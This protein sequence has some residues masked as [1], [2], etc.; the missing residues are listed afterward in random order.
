MSQKIFTDED[1]KAFAGLLP[2]APGASVPFTPEAFQS[3]EEA[4]RPVFRLR[5]YTNK[6]REYMGEHLKS[7][8]YGKDC[9][10]T[11]MESGAVAGWENLRSLPDGESIPFGKGILADLPDVVFFQIHDRI[12]VL[13][14][15][16]NKEEKLGL[17]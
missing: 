1:R 15:G 4:F 7:G 17:P 2:F 11:A 14:M 10:A 13:S 5:P 6:D 3:V 8:T 9:I 12:G 16:P